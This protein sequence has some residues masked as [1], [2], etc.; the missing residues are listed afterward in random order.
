MSDLEEMDSERLNE[1]ESI[2]YASIHYSD[3]TDE[4]GAVD[5]PAIVSLSDHDVRSMPPPV[6]QP[7]ELP[8]P[9][10]RF[11]SGTRVI[12]NNNAGQK[13]KSRYWAEGAEGQGQV[14][15]TEEQQ[16]TTN[17]TIP[18]AEVPPPPATKE[19]EKPKQKS[20]LQS[21]KKTTPN[22]PKSANQPSKQQQNEQ[23]KSQQTQQMKQ[24]QNQQ[25]KHQQKQQPKQQ[26]QNQQQKQQQNQKPKQQ[27]NQQSKQQQSQ[28]KKPLPKSP[29]VQKANPQANTPTKVN[30]EAYE[31]ERFDQRLLVAIP[32]NCPPKKQNKPQQNKQQQQQQN[33]QQQQKK[34]QQQNKQQQQS[35]PGAGPFGKAN[36]KLEQLQRLASK[37]QKSKQ[38]QLNKNQRKLQSKPVVFLELS[39]DEGEAQLT[40]QQRKLQSKPVEI[41][42]L[43]ENSESS[44]G[45][46]DVVLVPLPP[47]PIIDLDTSDGEQSCS[48]P[49]LFHEENAMDATDINMGLSCVTEPEEMGVVSGNTPPSM[50]SPCCSVMSSD[51]FIVQK[52]TSRFLAER[53]NANDEDLLVLTENAIRESFGQN[54]PNMEA[55]EGAVQDKETDIVIESSS[56]HEFVPPSRLEE[57]K[58]NYRVGDQQFR[59]LDVYE[60]ESDLTESG[61]YSKA[62]PKNAPTIIRSVDSLSDSSSLEEVV[63]PSVQKTKRLRKRSCSTNNH[64][65]SDANNEDGLNDSDSDDGVHSTG[66][67]GISRG[68]AVERCK[69]KIRRISVRR[70]SDEN[71]KKVAR[72][73][74]A[75][76]SASQETSSESATEAELPSAREIAERLLNQEQEKGV[77]QVQ[78]TPDDDMDNV[79]I[80]SDVGSKGE[81]EFRDAMTDRLAAV[82][83]RMDAQV[84]KS[85]EEQEQLDAS[86]YQSDEEDSRDKTADTTVQSEEDVDVSA[87]LQGADPEE[88]E[89]EVVKEEPGIQ[90]ELNLPELTDESLPSGG[91]LVGWNEEMCRFY[92]DS[93]NGEHFSL[94]KLQRSMSAHRQE[95]RLNTAD[96]YPV[97]RPRSHAKCTNCFEMG[98]VRSKCPRP[99]KPLVCFLCG[100]VG[101]AEPRCPNAICFG[102]GSKQAIYV[103]QCNKCS[104]HSRLVCQLCKMRGHGTDH[105]PD[106]WRRYHSTTRS[107]V[108][109]DSRVHYRNVQC[110]YCA[111]RHLFENCRQRIGDFRSTNYTSQIISHQ[112]VYRNR[113]GPLGFLGDL[114]SFFSIPFHFKWKSAS[115][116]K[117]SYYAKFLIQVNLAKT[118]SIKRKSTTALPEI[119]AKVYT[120]DYVPNAQVRAA[121]GEAKKSISKPK[122]SPVVEVI[123]GEKPAEKQPEKQ[124]PEENQTEKQQPKEQK[125]EEQQ[126][127]EETLEEQPGEDLSKE[128]QPVQEQPADDPP[129][130]VQPTDEPEEER[131]FSIQR[132]EITTNYQAPQQEM[133]TTRPPLAPHELDSDSNYSFS[134]HFEVPSS[135]TSDEQESQPLNRAISRPMASLPDVIPLSMD[136]DFELST[137]VQGISMCVNSSSSSSRKTTQ[138]PH[139]DSSDELPDVPSEG[140]IIMSREQSEYLFSPEGR[141]FLA[142]AAKQCQVSVRMDFKDYGYVLVIYGLKQHQEE[143]QVKLLR[144]NQEVKRKSI[145]FQKQKPPKRID[146]LIRFM[147][148]G[149]NSLTTNLGNAKNH[150]M[151]IKELEEMNTK[152]GFKLAE[153]KRRQLNMIL[154]GQ[155]GLLNGKTHL[156]QLLILLR[157]LVDEFSPDENATPQM[158]NEIEDHWRMIFTAYPHPN[159][160]SLL[161]SY[162]R[163]DQ[164]NRLP[165]LHID[166]VLLGLQPKKTPSQ[167]SSPSKRAPS[168]TPPPPAWQ[169]M[170]PPPPPKMLKKKQRQ[171]QQVQQQQQQNAKQQEQQNQRLQQQQ[172]QRMQ[173]QQQN[174]QQQQR[175]QQQ[176]Q[177]QQQRLQQQQKQNQQRLQQN[178]QQHQQQQRVQQQNNQ[179]QQLRRPQSN[180]MPFNNPQQRSRSDL[181]LR[182]TFNP[183][184]VRLLA[185]MDA[186]DRGSINKDANKPSMFWSR[187]S[188]KYLDDL[189]KMTSNTETVERLNRVLHRSQRGLLSHNDYR[190]V[191]RLHSLLCN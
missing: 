190:A 176:I 83:E 188:L 86:G 55:V 6:Q 152:N 105:C 59:A 49:E 181:Q 119:P 114:N 5:Q 139:P 2:L 44:N 39:D 137:N 73:H 102:C 30:H 109:L 70:N 96:R 174:Q 50:H 9:G 178:Q 67:P 159:Y 38:A 8:N 11:V 10:Q 157:R 33:K 81:A 45:D 155:A 163:M 170:A 29:V 118:Q 19:A 58:Q 69:R 134:E 78:E 127:K 98:H 24:P 75:K 130:E 121:Q 154:V 90:V 187:E 184:C 103:Q 122:Q 101:H 92:N 160:D 177:Q 65:Q 149:I 185:E 129:V 35:G 167:P 126:T 25:A 15:Q 161:N 16:A 112:K 140:K 42:D 166:P 62:K 3:G 191:I 22:Q 189:F 120:H 107:N 74:K 51:D 164:K 99:R 68:M 95:W 14:V 87:E 1:L 136:D 64:S 158:R 23:P 128:Q 175:L 93:W 108:E 131:S 145:E 116:P 43:S 168:P 132:E 97:A 60:S 173:Q 76:Q 47:A 156:D 80:G 34:Q 162:G 179:Q 117:N 180:Q 148:D 146:V 84:R 88:N 124:K 123:I 46:D 113:G 32:P 37:K 18:D 143:L 41:L 151:R 115:M 52:D 53:E 165:S 111:G 13:Q 72:I 26:Q 36:R 20:Q 138:D 91:S 27:Q 61:I 133:P 104:F 56:E 147:R 40:K 63:E 7:K 135:T 125:P 144:R 85:Q 171:E 141:N 4:Q 169:H 100:T 89:V 28:Q 110:S 182:Q 106:K 54:P 172:Q 142:E 71:P 66:V 79:S 21:P 12:N 48:P 183:E 82:F 17:K 77:D 31:E 186:N 57:I 150:Y 94:H 153:K